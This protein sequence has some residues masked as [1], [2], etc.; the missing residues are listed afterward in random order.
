ML[1]SRHAWLILI[2]YELS[3][4][5]PWP[6]FSTGDALMK[7]RLLQC[8]FSSWM[9]RKPH[10]HRQNHVMFIECSSFRKAKFNSLEIWST[11]RLRVLKTNVDITSTAFDDTAGAI[12]GK[13]QLFRLIW[14]KISPMVTSFS[15]AGLCSQNMFRGYLVFQAPPT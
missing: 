6:G 12:P 1:I 7:K 5:K 14:S 10:L 8:F 3:F 11:K 15:N 13:H 9:S 2:C 4:K